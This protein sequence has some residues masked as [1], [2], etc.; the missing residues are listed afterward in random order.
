MAASVESKR[1]SRVYGNGSNAEMYIGQEIPRPKSIH[2]ARMAP[3]TTKNIHEPASRDIQRATF[4][5]S[6]SVL[7]NRSSRF[8][9]DRLRTVSYVARRR[10]ASCLSNC[11]PI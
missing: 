10:S 7:S 5:A 11:R 4:M 9:L 3:K 1:T 8:V 6:D 2:R